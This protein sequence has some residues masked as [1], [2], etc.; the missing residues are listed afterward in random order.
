[1]NILTQE[2]RKRQAVV[3]LARKKG[4]SYAAQKYGVSLS[5]VKRWD[6]KYDGNDWRS[7]L[8]GSHR[9]HSH[10]KRHTE[11]EE[12]IIS[13]AEYSALAYLKIVLSGNS[14]IVPLYELAAF[15]LDDPMM[16]KHYS[17]N[18]I[19]SLIDKVDLEDIFIKLT[20]KDL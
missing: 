1:M 12:M 16:N 5:S 8:E 17:S 4:K 15:S 20:E 11:A 10:T 18:T 14:E 9:P 7:L 2:A 13:G 3:K 6:K 19:L